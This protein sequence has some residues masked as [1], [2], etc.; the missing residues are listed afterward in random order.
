MGLF[1]SEA[2]IEWSLE[3]RNRK[4]AAKLIDSICRVAKNGGGTVPLEPFLHILEF[5]AADIKRIVSQR[6]KLIVKCPQ[7]PGSPLDGT[8]FNRGKAMQNPIPRMEMMSAV[9]KIERIVQGR[10]QAQS[11][12]LRLTNVQGMTVFKELLKQGNGESVNMSY[13]VERLLLKPQSLTIF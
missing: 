9:M 11:N 7:K 4:S 5:D 13:K 2:I 6:E 12:F 3:G 8:F 1:G 10:F